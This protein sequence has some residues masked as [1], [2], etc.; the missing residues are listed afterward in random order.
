MS[1]IPD[2]VLINKVIDPNDQNFLLRIGNVGAVLLVH[3][4]LYITY[5]HPWAKVDEEESSRRIT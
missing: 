4:L 1:L 3:E 5:R 2:G